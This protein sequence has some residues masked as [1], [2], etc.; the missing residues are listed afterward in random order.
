MMKAS[1]RTTCWYALEPDLPM[2]CKAKQAYFYVHT[3]FFVSDEG[4]SVMRARANVQPRLMDNS[5]VI[6]GRRVDVEPVQPRAK[7]QRATT[8]LSTS[9]NLGNN[10]KLGNGRAARGGKLENVHPGWIS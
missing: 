3:N 4:I 8:S 5:R 2:C 1:F 9:A 10:G 6:T 7:I